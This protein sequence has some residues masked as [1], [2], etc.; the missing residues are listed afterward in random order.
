MNI[1]LE[2]KDLHS[3][4]SLQENPL[5]EIRKDGQATDDETESRSVARVVVYII[6]SIVSPTLTSFFWDRFMPNVH[7]VP[8]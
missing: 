4:L 3:V 1:L 5:H 8:E 2:S 7:P 6:P